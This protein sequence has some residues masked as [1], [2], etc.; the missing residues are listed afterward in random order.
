MYNS[1]D[2]QKDR[3]QMFGEK[4]ILLHFIYQPSSSSSS[5]I[6]A[7]RSFNQRQLGHVPRLNQQMR[8]YHDHYN[9]YTKRKRIVG[10]NVE[11]GSND[12][13]G[14]SPESQM[15]SKTHHRAARARSSPRSRPKCGY[16]RKRHDAP[17]ATT[18]FGTASTRFHQVIN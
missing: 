3:T 13:R 8:L 7:E 18:K 9:H 15:V 14:N 16:S 5:N 11:N 1:T 12:I 10:N 4:E 6:P 2:S 17:N